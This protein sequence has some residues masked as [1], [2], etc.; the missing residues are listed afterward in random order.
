MSSSRIARNLALPLAALSM[1]A[2][3]ALAQTVGKTAQPTPPSRPGGLQATPN[4]PPPPGGA[5]AG[6]P[7][8]GLCAQGF[9][10]TAEYKRN[11]P[12]NSQ[13][14]S[15]GMQVYDSYTC[16]GDAPR[17]LD[18]KAAAETGPKLVSA[19]RQGGG[20]TDASAPFH[21]RVGYEVKY[22]YAC[23]TPPITCL[24]KA[25]NGNASGVNVEVNIRQTH[26]GGGNN[27][28][29]K[30]TYYWMNG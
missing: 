23:N 15:S 4:T 12:G 3:T 27:L 17:C 11:P 29:Y 22:D 1:L 28:H 25:L 6:T 21:I 13:A 2:A 19:G 14:G 30:C 18:Q 16:S 8:T 5:Y 26:L 9:A 20:G 24:N 10:K 7:T